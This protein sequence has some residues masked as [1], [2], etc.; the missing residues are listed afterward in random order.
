MSELDK[1]K[2]WAFGWRQ[3]FLFSDFG[4]AKAWRRQA[5]AKHR[6]ELACREE[7]KHVAGPRCS[8]CERVGHDESQVACQERRQSAAIYAYVGSKRYP[9]P[10][11][12]DA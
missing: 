12:G 6:Y 10:E 1:A 5:W 2:F 11:G 3:A 9:R 4:G 7:K 8:F